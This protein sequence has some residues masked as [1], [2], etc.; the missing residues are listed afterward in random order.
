MQKVHRHTNAKAFLHLH[1]FQL[2]DLDEDGTI[3]ENE[4]ACIIQSALGVPELDVSNLFKEIDADETG[5]LSYG[6]LH[7]FIMKSTLTVIPTV[8]P[9]FLQN[10]CWFTYSF[11]GKL[12]QH[13]PRYFAYVQDASEKPNWKSLSLKEAGSEIFFDSVATL[14]YLCFLYFSDEFKDFALKHPEYAKLFTTYLD[15]QRYQLG[16]L[17]EDDIQPPEAK[18]TPVGN[19][20]PVSETRPVARN[21]VCPAD[22]EEDNSGTSDKKDD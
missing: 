22:N 16:M 1:L 5:K 13:R 14:Q 17:E 19:A 3:T 8:T 20:V 11:W 7:P 4:F 15:L 2:F 12:L 6:K 9:L 21:K 10:I 18:Y